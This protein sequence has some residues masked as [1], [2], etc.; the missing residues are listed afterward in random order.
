MSL[1]RQPHHEG[2]HPRRSRLSRGE[3]ALRERGNYSDSLKRGKLRKVGNN[4]HS[5]DWRREW[6]SLKRELERAGITRCER[7]GTEFA[8][9]P[10]HS[11]KR[12]HIT[13]RTEMR[14]IALLCRECHRLHDE[15]MTHEEMARSIRAII[16]GRDHEACFRIA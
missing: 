14:E 2:F 12:R 11:L 13:N 1:P 4:S 5:K 9:T 10:A 8:L 16:A 6:P 3:K 15:G 7:C